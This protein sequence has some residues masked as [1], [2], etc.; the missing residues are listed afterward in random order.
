[1][2]SVKLALTETRNCH[3]KRS[4]VENRKSGLMKGIG[5]GWKTPWRGSR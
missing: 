1:M 5:N 4:H 3:G 2:I